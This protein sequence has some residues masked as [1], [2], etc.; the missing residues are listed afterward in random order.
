MLQAKIAA[1]SHPFK[2]ALAMLGSEGRRHLSYYVIPNG[3]T[4]MA[5]YDVIQLIGTSSES[6]GKSRRQ[7]GRTSLQIS[8][9]S[10]CRRS[11]RTRY[12]TGREGKGGSLSRESQTIVQIRAAHWPGRLGFLNR[13]RRTW[14]GRIADEDQGNLPPANL[15]GH[16]HYTTIEAGTPIAAIA[17]RWRLKPTRLCTIS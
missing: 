14:T 7:R 3:R 11:R 2:V 10:S 17:V 4:D 5:M 9:R 12:A 13:S 1:Y 15:F 8:P 6:M 16:E